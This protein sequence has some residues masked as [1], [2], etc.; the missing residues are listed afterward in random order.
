MLRSLARLEPLNTTTL[1]TCVQ[2]TLFYHVIK[3]LVSL[4]EFTLADI[5]DKPS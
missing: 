1:L 3:E 5:L 2:N 4:T